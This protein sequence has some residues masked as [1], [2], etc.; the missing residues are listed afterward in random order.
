MA[1]DTLVPERL[2]AAYTD[3]TAA[4]KKHF[5]DGGQVCGYFGTGMPIEIAIATGHMPM[6]LMPLPGPT[7]NADEWLHDT[8]DPQLRLIFDQL[9]GN[10]VGFIDLAVAVSQFTGD[11][12]VFFHA[13]ELLR[14]GVGGHIPPLHHYSLLALRHQAVRE[15]GRMEMDGL[16]RRLRANSGQEAT[17][18]ELRKAID[19]VNAIRTQWRKLDTLRRQGAV[20]G[21]DA[22]TLMAPQRFMAGDDYLAEITRVVASL[23][24]RQLPGTK[25][26]VVSSTKLSDNRL[27]K[28]LEAGGLLVVAED[29]IWGARSATPDIAAGDDPMQAIYDHYYKHV[30]N[31]S[32]YPHTERLAWFY[33]NAVDP[34]IDAVIIHMPRSDHHL[35]WDYPRM[36]DFLYE[37]N[38][39]HLMTREDSTTAEGVAALTAQAAKFN[40]G[41]QE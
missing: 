36:R 13:R 21:T 10:D 24:G 41:I 35:G 39:P 28:A 4:A 30:P 7:P 15:F 16:A 14:Q 1:M 2:M 31:A 22:L 27:H 3:R 18:A 25:V 23:E 38:V 12:Q 5:N 34:G 32:I 19:Q 40:A 20:S 33:A 17:P 29:D 11:S 26:L 9:I 37:K 6:A 8:Y